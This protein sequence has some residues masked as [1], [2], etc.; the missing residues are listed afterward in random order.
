[1][2]RAAISKPAWLYNYLTQPKWRMENMLEH[3]PHGALAD[4]VLDNVN[5][6]FDASVTWEDAR[7]LMNAWGD[8]FIQATIGKTGFAFKILRICS[9]NQKSFYHFNPG[10]FVFRLPRASLRVLKIKN[11]P[12][13]NQ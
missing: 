4:K 1:M 13:F 12:L 11:P 5:K 3:L 10:F 9:S 7:E 6:Q 8:K 2:A